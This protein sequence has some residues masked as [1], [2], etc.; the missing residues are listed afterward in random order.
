MYLRSFIL[1]PHAPTTTQI[2]G[3]DVPVLLVDVEGLYAVDPMSSMRKSDVNK[4]YFT[5][6]WILVFF[7]SSTI[8]FLHRTTSWNERDETILKDLADAI[9]DFKSNRQSDILFKKNCP[10]VFAYIAQNFGQTWTLEQVQGKSAQEED[11]CMRT[12]LFPALKQIGYPL[13]LCGTI[14]TRGVT[15][16]RDVSLSGFQFLAEPWTVDVIS[17][18]AL[19]N[20]DNKF[21]VK[22][23]W[24][25]V[26]VTECGDDHEIQNRTALEHCGHVQYHVAAI[27][28]EVLQQYT[29]CFSRVYFAILE[30]EVS[31][32][33]RAFAK[34][35][36]KM[37]EKAE[38]SPVALDVPAVGRVSCAQFLSLA[39]FQ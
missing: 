37:V 34:Q 25:N 36:E 31:C 23:D 17:A 5:R 24:R 3:C 28:K 18:A 39:T 26:P 21:T 10:S 29:G 4:Y 33:C 9:S 12:S 14:F 22:E 13:P 20:V 19:C 6:L 27:F 7:M 2:P 32:K 11:L 1:G 30:S 16:F 15:V 8:L 35:F 38:F